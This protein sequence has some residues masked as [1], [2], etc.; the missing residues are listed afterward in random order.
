MQPSQRS[1]A[2][3]AALHE[4]T[5]RLN[6]FGRMGEAAPAVHPFGA[7]QQAASMLPY[8]Y[9][10][11]ALPGSQQWGTDQQA[12]H[13]HQRG[14]Q[15]ISEWSRSVQAMNAPQLQQE[16]HLQHSFFPS[17]AAQSGAVDAAPV[18]IPLSWIVTL[19]RY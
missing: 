15:C 17:C 10:V 5:S 11:L 8:S 1:P 6:P 12:A 16:Q 7:E 19:H 9:S 2:Q 3:E 4:S 18:F 13:A 14:L